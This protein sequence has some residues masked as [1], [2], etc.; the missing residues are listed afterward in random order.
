MIKKTS[1][2]LI[3]I[4]LIGGLI[5]ALL[6]YW[7]V[8]IP[9]KK[10]PKKETTSERQ[11]E[12]I[13]LKLAKEIMSQQKESNIS[14]NL[15]RLA[16]GE[17]KKI[18]VGEAAPLTDEVKVAI[19]AFYTDESSLKGE[20]TFWRREGKWYLVE[21][22]REPRLPN[23]PTGTLVKELSSE[24]IK[25]GKKIVAQQQKHQEIITDLVTGQVKELT[26]DRADLRTEASFVDTTI[27]YA[28]GKKTKVI[29][30]LIFQGGS[31][32]LV[33]ITLE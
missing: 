15:R 24:D 10:L 25:L 3:A 22:T 2:A 31:W 19:E 27:N 14:P 33:T 29:V 13:E 21:V 4:L 20:M 23:P 1:L 17:I 28:N 12:K 11:R 6:Y 18:T 16:E 7:L 9:K 8:F 5:G 32:Y 30:E 26:F